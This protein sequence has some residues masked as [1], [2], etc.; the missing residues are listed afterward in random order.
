MCLTVCNNL[1]VNSHF[2]LA[3]IKVARICQC[4]QVKKQIY[5]C[6]TFPPC[7]NLAYSTNIFD[8]CVI[9]TLAWILAFRI[10]LCFQ[11]LSSVEKKWP[12]SGFYCRN[13]FSMK[14]FCARLS[15]IR[16]LV[17]R[18]NDFLSKSRLKTL[19]KNRT[20]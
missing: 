14:K 1:P 11:W 4:K 16:P 8:D 2:L 15:W 19:N 10:L 17:G 7:K 18:V 12:L 9:F 13:I 3:R 20:K 6:V 5:C